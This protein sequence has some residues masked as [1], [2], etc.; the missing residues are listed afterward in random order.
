MNK[1][2]LGN[3]HICSNCGTKFFD[4][5]KEVPTCPNCGTEIVIRTKPR[6]GRPPLNKK[7]KN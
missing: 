2:K 7:L 4:L 1:E 3:K 5:K 6:L